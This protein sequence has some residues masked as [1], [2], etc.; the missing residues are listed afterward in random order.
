[1]FLFHSSCI[2]NF[3]SRTAGVTKPSGSK[4]ILIKPSIS[5]LVA[6]RFFLIDLIFSMSLCLSLIATT[7]RGH[8]PLAFR[9]D[10]C[11]CLLILQC[12]LMTKLYWCTYSLFCIYFAAK[13]GSRL[14]FLSN[15]YKRVQAKFRLLI[16][17]GWSF[18]HNN[19]TLWWLFSNDTVLSRVWIALCSSFEKAVEVSLCFVSYDS[20]PRNFQRFGRVE[21]LW[22]F[23]RNY[24][25]W[26]FC[27]YPFHLIRPILM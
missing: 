20:I 14:N 9:L 15:E 12:L 4:M 27:C 6:G 16:S 18:F 22:N 25:I 3:G 19:P 17:E 8:R 26:Y 2:I 1:M 7:R 21:D 5:L 23:E 24:L 11:L 13:D 10:L